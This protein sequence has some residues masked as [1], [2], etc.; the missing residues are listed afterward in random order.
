[1]P[2]VMAPGGSMDPA[3]T[4][5]AAVPVWQAAAAATDQ[6]ASNRVIGR[7]RSTDGKEGA[8][9]TDSTTALAVGPCDVMLFENRL[10][11]AGGLNSPRAGEG[12]D[13]AGCSRHCG[14]PVV[15]EAVDA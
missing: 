14:V 8:T 13:L 9:T 6:L 5:T 2:G 1:M 10:W 3:G 11:H 12:R 7:D 4:A 15:W